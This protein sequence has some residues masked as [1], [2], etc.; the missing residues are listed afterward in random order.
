MLKKTLKSNIFVNPC[1]E[2]AMWEHYRA[3]KIKKIVLKVAKQN[4]SNKVKNNVHSILFHKKD[5]F[6]D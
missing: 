5:R 3:P 2:E 4:F 6:N 1:L